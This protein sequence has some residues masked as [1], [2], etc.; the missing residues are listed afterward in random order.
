MNETDER[1]IRRVLAAYTELWLQHRMDEWGELFTE[2]SDFVTHRGIWWRTRQENVVGHKDVPASVLA[3]KGNYRQEVLSVQG[4]TPDVALVH[5]RWSWPDH[6]LPSAPTGED[7]E[8]IVTLVMVRR[9]GKWLIRA[10]HNT[11]RNGLDDFDPR[12]E[13]K[14][15]HTAGSAGLDT[16]SARP[17][18]S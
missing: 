14:S 18:P 6:Q 4:V 3:Q 17:T 10:A 8:G 16:S 15:T 12:R 1:N 9:E 11:R 2:D 13:E 7:R 5:T